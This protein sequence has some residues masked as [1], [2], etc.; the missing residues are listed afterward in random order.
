[1]VKK[2]ASTST[3]IADLSDFEKLNPPIMLNNIAKNNIHANVP[4]IEPIIDVEE[5]PQKG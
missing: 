5:V 1:M 2:K 3:K 4:I